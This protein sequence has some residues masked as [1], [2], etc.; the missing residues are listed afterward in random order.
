MANFVNWLKDTILSGIDY[1]KNSVASGRDWIKENIIDRFQEDE[2]E[3]E[4]FVTADE[5]EEEEEA[6]VITQLDQA[7]QGYAKSYEIS[8][9]NNK[10]PLLQ[11][12]KTRE[13]LESHIQNLLTS[14]NGLK[15][16]ESL[17]VTLSKISDGETISNTPVFF[18]T[19]QTIINNTEIMVALEATQQMILNKIA[20]WISE[21]SGWTIKSVDHHYLNVVT[22]QPLAGSSYIKLP[23]ELQNNMKGLINLQNKDQE[24]FRWC[25]IRHLNPQAK[26]PQR[27]KKVDREYIKNLN[28]SGIEFPVTIKQYNKIE[29]Q[30]NIN[31][32]VF[33]YEEE[34]QYPIYISKEKN[35][36]VLNL[37]LITEEKGNHYVLIKDFNRFMHNITKHKNKKHFCMHCLQHFTNERI[38]NNHKENCILI[39]GTQGIKMPT[40][41]EN[42]L[43]FNGFKKQLPV[44]FVIYADFEAI[45]EKIDSCQPNDNKSYTEAYQNHRDCGYGYKVVCCYDDK[46]TKE[47]VIYRGEKA[48]YKFL[49]A[50]LKEVQYCREVKEKELNKELNM[51]EDDEEKFKKADKCHICEEKFLFSISNCCYSCK[52]EICEIGKKQFSKFKQIVLN[53]KECKEKFEMETKKVRDH[54]HITGKYRGAA[55]VKCNLNFQITDKIP[56]IFH[57]L[58]GYD[59]HFIIQEIGEII[60]KHP[61]KVEGKEEEKEMNINIIPN[62]M[63]KYLS[64]MLGKHLTFIDSF[65]F[66]SSSL[67]KLVSNLPK[68]SSSFKYTSKRFGE[69]EKLD[70]MTRKGVYPYDYMD[71]FN[72]FNEQLPTKEDFFSILNN[73]HI[74]DEDYNHALKVWKTFSLKNMGEYH[75]LYLTSDILLLADVFEN[76]R[77]TCLEYYNL[78]PCHYF[79]SPGLAWD[80]MLK[81]TKIQLE[82]MT[83]VDMYLFIEKGLRGGISYIAN[84][85]GKANNKYMKDYNVNEPSNYIMYL[86]ANNLYG[87][88][89]CQYL[90]TGGFRWFTKKDI[91]ELN[92]LDPNDYLFQYSETDEKGLIFEVDLEY[93]EELHDLHNNYPLAP[94]KIKVTKDM[95]S[96]YSRK[97]AEKF[98]IS[99]GLVHKLIPTL[100]KKEKYVLHYRNLQLYVN[101]GMKLTKIHRVLEFNQS[102]WLK[103]YIDFNTQKRTNA[104]NSFEKDFF[105]L[106]NNSVFGKTM[107]NIRKRVNVKLITDK[108]QLLKWASKPTFVNSKIFNENLVALNKIKEQIKLNK[109]AYVG[110]C[111]LDLSKTLMYDFHYNYIKQ[112]YGSKAKL[113]FT[114]TDSLTY[115]IEAE[116]V[117]QDFWK[118]KDLFDNSDYPENSPYFYKKNKKVIGKFKDEAAGVPIIEFVGLRSKMY[119]YIKE[120]DGKIKEQKTA[121]GIKKNIIKN[122]IKH[123]NYKETLFNNKQMH[124]KMKTIRSQ[125][126]QIKSYEINKVSLSCYDDKR[127]IKEDGIHTYAYEHFTI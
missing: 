80:A 117:Y 74:S 35:E 62:N 106:M 52:L 31:I 113:L 110:M 72:K 114:D 66:M 70:L 1:I 108:K 92:D 107:E 64:I 11:L 6:P 14:M 79:T 46:F 85:Y 53:C 44:P 27:I 18:S 48:V 55:H 47:A 104:K 99:T 25:H 57:N 81:M 41:K 21:G 121:K 7:L 4:E 51:T 8:I 42:I 9:I 30:N 96:D 50:M 111:I 15:F 73:E 97:M 112:K 65:Q 24:C 115:E 10:D 98:N 82:L 32:N 123:N 38:L 71:S 13:A 61:I 103:Q 37:L 75:D 29:K 122:N 58:R 12:Q 23:E 56:V 33:G 2:G 118:D 102:P 84:R 3:E 119:S 88:A 49:E 60:K 26:D 126:H 45:T 120:E 105:K 127:Y 77:K 39:N 54:C 40:K 20:I 63:E 91:Q 34:L 68:D 90:P 5:G 86:D 101:L 83:D 124:H 17:K 28:Y 69:G 95:I 16:L 109:P 100:G 125:N 78:D 87:W 116:D 93:P 59:S 89:M 76:F 94:E 43:K 19:P 67:D 22:F 36:D